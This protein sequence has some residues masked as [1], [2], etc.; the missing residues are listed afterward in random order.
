V[1]ETKTGHKPT[2]ILQLNVALACFWGEAVGFSLVSCTTVYSVN[3]LPKGECSSLS[4]AE[5]SDMW[6]HALEGVDTHKSGPDSR[7]NLPSGRRS[8]VY[9]LSSVVE[10]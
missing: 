6:N 5:E 9:E 2:H 7:D 1:L 10:T 3:Q 8:V 4:S